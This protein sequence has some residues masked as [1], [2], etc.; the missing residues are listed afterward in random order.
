[1]TEVLAFG[2]RTG[3]WFAL[4]FFAVISGA[5]G[6]AVAR[7]IGVRSKNR[8][9][10]LGRTVGTLFFAGPVVLVYWSMLSGF[11]EAEIHGAS[12][13][14]HYL[15][16]G[17][18]IETPLAHTR[19]RIAPAYRN[20]VRLVLATDYGVFESTPTPR[21]VANAGLARFN[22]RLSVQ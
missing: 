20:R 19:P 21:N 9:P 6:W 4:I 1:M 11:Y 5:L 16:P 22:E 8:N 12:L 14:L 17:L 10:S 13:R 2:S 7:Q 15:V 18:S 3:S